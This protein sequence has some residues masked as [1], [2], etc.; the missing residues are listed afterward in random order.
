MGLSRILL[1]IELISR[2]TLIPAICKPVDI[3]AQLVRLL[4]KEIFEE[5]LV[6]SQTASI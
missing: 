1:G 6:T 4:Q 2:S 3:G 5:L